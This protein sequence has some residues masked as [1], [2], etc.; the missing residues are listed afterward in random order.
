MPFEHNIPKDKQHSC[1]FEIFRRFEGSKPSSEPENIV[2]F[3]FS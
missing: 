1:S 2:F 3:H